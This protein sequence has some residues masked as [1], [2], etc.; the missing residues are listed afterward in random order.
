M[1]KKPTL[2]WSGK[3][4]Q[5]AKMYPP[6]TNGYSNDEETKFFRQV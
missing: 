5:R 2:K 3:F 4:G 1:M 6:R